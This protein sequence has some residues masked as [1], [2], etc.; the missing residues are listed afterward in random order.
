MLLHCYGCDVL[1]SLLVVFVSWALWELWCL[2]SRWVVLVSRAWFRWC[3]VPGDS[4]YPLL[5]LW[6]RQFEL[7]SVCLSLVSACVDV[8]VLVLSRWV[9]VLRLRLLRSVLLQRRDSRLSRV[10]RLL[11]LRR[12]LALLLSLRFLE[13]LNCDEFD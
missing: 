13:L 12:M 5:A 9:R 4:D 10:L 11:R 7:C 6:C 1:A 3:R 8:D 2:L